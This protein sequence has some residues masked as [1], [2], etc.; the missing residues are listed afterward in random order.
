MRPED[1]VALACIGAMVGACWF[2]C[3]LSRPIKRRK[4]SLWS[5][6]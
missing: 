3:P 5:M 1:F 4:E 6:F 2:A